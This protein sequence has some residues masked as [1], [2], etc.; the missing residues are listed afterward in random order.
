M[1]EE[2]IKRLEKAGWKVGD[3]E[4]FVE[5]YFKEVFKINRE[6]FPHTA[7]TYEEFLAETEEERKVAISNVKKNN[8]KKALKELTEETEK[9]GLYEHQKKEEKK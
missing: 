9:L 1:D 4:D 3:A 2:K 5:G 6:M 8:Q 7:M